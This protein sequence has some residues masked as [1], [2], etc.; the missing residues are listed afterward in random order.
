MSTVSLWLLPIF[1]ILLIGMVVAVGW[2]IWFLSR[3][4]KEQ[5]AG[6]QAT[7]AGS[8]AP[9]PPSNTTGPLYLLGIKRDLE[10]GWEFHVQGMRYRSLAAVPDPQLRAEVE[11]AIR[12]LG[13]F[14]GKARGPVE[15]SSAGGQTP[16][17][18]S[19]PPRPDRATFTETAEPGD[20]STRR[21]TPP[22]GSIPVIDIAQEI[23]DIIEE[24]QAQTPVLQGHA[25]DLQSTPGG[26]ITFLVDG[27]VYAD[28]AE[29]P[30]PQIQALIRRATQEWERR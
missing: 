13:T 18:V 29:I 15:A 7:V 1:V 3:R 8:E 10:G 21:T 22:G 17:R 26:G 19:P 11:L 16:P 5:S 12:Q 2:L 20:P 6:Q 23:T 14:L 30:D 28:I 9:T 27:H 24:I 4:G 25:V